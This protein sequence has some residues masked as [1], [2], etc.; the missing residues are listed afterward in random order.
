MNF[1]L[2]LLT[3][4]QNS[5]PIQA[6]PEEFF[7]KFRADL[8]GAQE[9]NF[10]RSSVLFA[11]LGEWIEISFLNFLNKH[12]WVVLLLFLVLDSPFIAIHGI[13]QFAIQLFSISIVLTSRHVHDSRY[14]TVV[15]TLALLTPI[16]YTII[17]LNP[18]WLPLSN[19]TAWL[20][21]NLIGL[22][23]VLMVDFVCIVKVMVVYGFRPDLKVLAVA[24]AFFA[25]FGQVQFAM[26]HLFIYDSSLSQMET[27]A[28]FLHAFS[29]PILFTGA[30]AFGWAYLHAKKLVTR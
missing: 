7:E 12:T 6:K 20:S 27:V 18:W 5:L 14:R 3:K 23:L 22:G 11:A 26:S 15:R 21:Q 29:L 13:E 8:L 4:L 30:I 17:F 28:E 2:W 25:I 10:S 24:Q 9:M 19:K 16:L 1:D